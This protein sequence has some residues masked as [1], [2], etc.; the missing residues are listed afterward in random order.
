MDATYIF[1]KRITLYPLT[2]RMKNAA[3]NLQLIAREEMVP[4]RRFASVQCVSRRGR[5]GSGYKENR[6]YCARGKLT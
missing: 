1:E 5:G 6:A 3:L 4:I 2:F